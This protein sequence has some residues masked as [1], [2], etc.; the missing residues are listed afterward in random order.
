MDKKKYVVKIERKNGKVYYLAKMR[1]VRHKD[2]TISLNAE[3]AFSDK[4][5]C[6]IVYTSE[7]QARWVAAS[8]KGAMAEE[9]AQ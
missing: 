4:A 7:W 9:T 3:G 8:F 1:S 6:A 2:G 5:E